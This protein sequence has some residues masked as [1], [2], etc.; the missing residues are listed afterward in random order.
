M[1][2][3]PR[4]SQAYYN[5]V[6]GAVPT[7]NTT[8]NVPVSWKFPCNAVMPNLHLSFTNGSVMMSARQMSYHDPDADNSKID[9]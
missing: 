9:H 3:D 1:L 5:S 7:A 8:D 4:V 6:H 2:V